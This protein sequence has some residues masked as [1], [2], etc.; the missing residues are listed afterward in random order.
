MTAIFCSTAFSFLT[1]PTTALAVCTESRR[2]YKWKRR[3]CGSRSPLLSLCQTLHGKSLPAMT[4]NISLNNHVL[5]MLT[6]QML[7][8]VVVCK[9]NVNID[10]RDATGKSGDTQGWLSPIHR[11]LGLMQPNSCTSAAVQQLLLCLS[12]AVSRPVEIPLSNRESARE[13]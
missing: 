4:N 6:H 5:L 3:K 11:V 9:L 1:T 8:Y 10:V 13:H 12:I 7:T 2:C